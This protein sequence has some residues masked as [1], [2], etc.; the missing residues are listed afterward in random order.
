MTINLLASFVHIHEIS[1][2]K[3]INHFNSIIN[4]FQTHSIILDHNLTEVIKLI[5][6]ISPFL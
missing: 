4:Y 6:A 5:D 1:I 2:I 3:D